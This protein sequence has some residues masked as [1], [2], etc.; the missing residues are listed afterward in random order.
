LLSVVTS[1]VALFPTAV[2]LA[3]ST[4]SRDFASLTIPDI[5]RVFSWAT[6]KDGRK[7]AAARDAVWRQ[8]FIVCAA[9]RLGC[10]QAE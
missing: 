1:D 3:P 10:Q 6:P 2:T 5:V 4:G 9:A 7:N 8:Y